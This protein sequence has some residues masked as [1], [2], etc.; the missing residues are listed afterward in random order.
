MYIRKN[1]TVVRKSCRYST[2]YVLH[3]NLYV[4]LPAIRYSLPYVV[5]TPVLNF[6]IDLFTLS[7]FNHSAAVDIDIAARLMERLS[8]R[9]SLIILGTM[10]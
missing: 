9:G 2:L 3:T 7:L 4:N 10:L 1:Y 5:F 6:F 8:S